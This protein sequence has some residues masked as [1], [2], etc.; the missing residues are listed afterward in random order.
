MT[1]AIALIVPLVTPVIRFVHIHMNKQ[2][3]EAQSSGGIPSNANDLGAWAIKFRYSQR[4]LEGPLYHYYGACWSFSYALE[5]N[6]ED[7]E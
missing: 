6:M 5:M 4:I 7:I 2:L 3:D 1:A